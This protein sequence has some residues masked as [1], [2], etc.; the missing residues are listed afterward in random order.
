VTGLETPRP[1][2]PE[3][4]E[5][6]RWVDVPD[7]SWRIEEGKPCRRRLPGS[8]SAQCPRE[9]VA[10]LNRGRH[11]P[12]LGRTASWWAYCPDHLYGRWIKDGVVWFRKL[13]RI[14]DG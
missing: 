1:T 2:P 8:K 13:E 3:A 6:Y 10:A 9:S 12:G 11:T 5:G 14:S 7:A 4:P